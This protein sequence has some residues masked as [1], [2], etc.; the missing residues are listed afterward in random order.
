MCVFERRAHIHRIFVKTTCF[1]REGGKLSE[2]QGSLLYFIF[3]SDFDYGVFFHRDRV[4]IRSVKVG[5]DNISKLLRYMIHAMVPVLVRKRRKRR[6]DLLPMHGDE[7]GLL[8]DVERRLVDISGH[9]GCFLG[10][11][12]PHSSTYNDYRFTTG[13]L[14]QVD[15]KRTEYATIGSG[16]TWM[17]LWT[18]L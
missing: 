3:I 1:L 13:F 4:R 14:V 18:R 2:N 9:T 16:P 10:D 17:S 11:N 8:V 6:V 12:F 7:I 5:R 15:E